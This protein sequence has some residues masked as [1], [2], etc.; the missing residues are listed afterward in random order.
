MGIKK[1]NTRAFCLKILYKILHKNVF[2]SDALIKYQNEF[3]E[4]NDNDKK[5]IYQLVVTLIRR[6]G[7]IEKII[8]LYLEKPIRNPEIKIVLQIG[9]AQIIYLRTPNYA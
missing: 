8:N 7:Y 2:F 4:F 1:N 5:Y 3:D 6:L 9:V